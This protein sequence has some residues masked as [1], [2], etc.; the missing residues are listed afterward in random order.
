L[1]SNPYGDSNQSYLKHGDIRIRSYHVKGALKDVLPVD[2]R[3]SLVPAQHIMSNEAA[4][5]S[6]A[7]RAKYDAQEL[8]LP[9]RPFACNPAGK[10]RKGKEPES[11]KR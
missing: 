11:M 8:Y 7:Y 5:A 6:Q 10:T 1:G 2:G 4:E 3:I 9:G